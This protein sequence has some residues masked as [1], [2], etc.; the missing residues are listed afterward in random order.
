MDYLDLDIAWVGARPRGARAEVVENR[1]N[2]V[3]Q[4]RLTGNFGPNRQLHLADVGLESNAFTATGVRL[5]S[6]IVPVKLNSVGRS[7]IHSA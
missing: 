5:R 7:M 6:A 2:V 4:G 3:A 1:A